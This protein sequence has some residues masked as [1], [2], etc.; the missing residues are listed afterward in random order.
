MLLA[1]DTSTSLTGLACYEQDR[2]LGECAW[3]SGRNHTAHLLAHLHMLMDHIGRNAT[4]VQ[5]VAI[6][7]GPGSW[8]GLRVGMSLAKGMAMAGNLAIIGV[9]TLDALA[10]QQRQPGIVLYPLIRL[11]RDRFATAAFQQNDTWQRLGD[12]R[13]VT[14]DGLCAE[15]DGPAL[16]CGDIDANIQQQ[17]QQHIGERAQFPTVAANLRRPG[18]LAEVAWQ[19]FTDGE[20]DTLARLEPLYLGEPVKKVAKQA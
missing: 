2:L 16:F 6:A 9:G 15:I 17:L 18:F 1:I 10:Y 4:D 7:L 14:L 5:V 12:Y 19:R 3:E 13:N 20:H 11:G 8:S